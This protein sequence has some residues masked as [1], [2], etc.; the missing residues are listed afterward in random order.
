MSEIDYSKPPAEAYPLDIYKKAYE[1]A[2]TGAIITAVGR[3]TFVSLDKKF[4]GRNAKEGDTGAY[5]ASIVIPSS[6]DIEALKTD[7][8]RAFIEKFGNKEGIWNHPS[9]NKPIRDAGEMLE[10]DGVTLKPGHVKGWAMIRANTFKNRPGILNKDGVNFAD[11]AAEQQR[12]L[13]DLIAEEVYSGCWVR[14]SVKAKGYDNESK[15]VKWWLNNVQK[16]CDGDALYSGGAKAESD[17]GAPTTG[18]TPMAA[19][20]AGSIFD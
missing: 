6:C 11:V 9:F 16:I 12:P 7:A 14:L 10:E 2:T 1:N 8:K 3:L 5:V 20:S 17:F 19:A 13:E 15:G 4:V 18:S